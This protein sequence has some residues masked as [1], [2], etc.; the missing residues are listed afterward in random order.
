M[1]SLFRTI[2]ET[3]LLKEPSDSSALTEPRVELSS[4]EVV[5]AVGD[6]VTEMVGAMKLVWLKV[7]NGKGEGFIDRENLESVDQPMLPDEELPEELHR[8]INLSTLAQFCF[9]NAF[10]HGSNS[11]LLMA[12]A[13]LASGKEWNNSHA[14]AADSGGLVGI[15]RFS[16]EKWQAALDS[17]GTGAGIPPSAITGSISQ[18]EL[19]ALITAS[20]WKK[21]ELALARPVRG[22]DLLLSFLASANV[23]AKCLLGSQDADLKAVLPEPELQNLLTSMKGMDGFAA[24][25]A[26]EPVSTL[27]EKLA[28]ALDAGFEFVRKFATELLSAGEPDAGSDLSTTTDEVLEEESV[29]GDDSELPENGGVDPAADAPP[30][31]ATKLQEGHLVALWRRS[32]FPFDD[33]GI[34]LFGI[35]GCLPVDF[36]GTGFQKSHALTFPSIDYKEMRCTI[37]QW[38]PGK[39]IALFPG[40]TVPFSEL[41]T[42]RVNHGG[43][44]VNQMGRGRHLN[45]APEFHKRREGKGGHW[46]ILQESDCTFQRTG[47]NATYDKSDKWGTGRPGDNIHCAFHMGGPASI[48]RS[49]FSSAG[50]QVVAGTVKKGK[51]DS[52]SGPWRKFI[53]PFKPGGQ[54]SAEY[55]LFS[56]DEVQQMMVNQ[57]AGKTYVLRFGS[58]GPLVEE[59]QKKLAAKTG[60]LIKADGKFGKNTF[61]AVIAFQQKTFGPNADDGIVGPDTA[62]KLGIAL[63]LFDFEKAVKGEAGIASAPGQQDGP[64]GTAGGGASDGLAPLTKSFVLGFAPVPPG[65]QQQERHAKYLDYLTSADCAAVLDHFGI[66]KSKLRIAHFFAQAAHETGGFSLLRESLFYTTIGA[67]RDAFDRASG[68]SDAFIENNILRD[69]PAM[70]AWAYG[71]R[72]DNRPGTDDGFDYRGGGI[73][74]TTGRENYKKLGKRMQDRFG[75]GE[76][77][78]DS[79]DL[80]EDL[81]LSLRASGFEWE[82]MDANALADAGLVKKISRGLNRGNPNSTKPA[83][84]EAERIALLGKIK[85]LLGI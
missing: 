52:E 79:P 66:S 26:D 85:G 38:N 83:N 80:I 57:Y 68:F 12:L 50:C 70:G 71:D 1:P 23:A 5:E 59:L 10:D 65:A 58:Q 2:I 21:L 7:R 28:I 81:R 15:Y 56:G 33:R 8:K 82:D 11:S 19:A 36:S 22:V 76:G 14:N 60:M 4:G 35:R 62:A 61:D 32:M 64:G 41:I 63:P 78:G 69:E 77:L 30:L 49:I 74:Q 51:R 34:I 54:K 16:V 47:D 13:F 27:I 43:T 84:G 48:P 42:K 39:G 9:D 31:N 18:C 53:E 20:D 55:V 45:Y 37:G 29:P 6:E 40:S 25:G 67:V 24:V 73:F 3:T 17:L 72:F 75:M 46:A 44:Q